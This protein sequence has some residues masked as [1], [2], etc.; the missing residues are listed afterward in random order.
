[1][2]DVQLRIRNLMKTFDPGLFE[3]KKEILKGLS[4][5]VRRGEVFGFLG[6]NGAGKTTT[7]KAVCDLIKPDSGDIEVCGFRHDDLRAKRKVGFM[8]ESP[9]FYQYLKGREFL[10][11]YADL[12][13]LSRLR[14]KNRVRE[15]LAMVG[16]EKHQSNP[17]KTFSKG[18]LQR[19]ALA[20]AL[21]GEPELLILDEPLSGLDPIGRRDVRDIILD[22]KAGGTTIFFSSHIIPD[23]EAI[24]DR[25]GI[26]SGGRIQAVGS[27]REIVARE[28]ETYE[29]TFTGIGPDQLKTP[30]LSAHCG[31][32]A[33]WVQIVAGERDP[34]IAELASG[35]G[36]LIKLSP[37]HSNLED[38]LLRHYEEA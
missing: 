3:T 32:E 23:V 19:M 18:M 16:M 30:F 24:C 26:I 2:P 14:A 37:L 33:S 31:S 22:L 15:V 12:L 34:L 13:G 36:H 8:P 4:L 21:L 17:M 29:A 38:Y 9:Y 10:Y 1:M 7:I 25:V 6:P 27:V 35:G 28:V 5:E 20:Q 11:F